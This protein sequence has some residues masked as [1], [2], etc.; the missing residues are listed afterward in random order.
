MAVSLAPN[1][2]IPC[3]YTEALNA[4]AAEVALNLEWGNFSQSGPSHDPTF[5]IKVNAGNDI[6]AE[7][8]GK[9]K[10]EAKNSAAKILLEILKQKY[11]IDS[12]A[13]DNV[14]RTPSPASTINYISMLN[15]YSQRMRTPIQVS[16]RQLATGMDHKPK[17]GC[18]YSV[19]GKKYPE[20]FGKNKNEAKREAARQMYEEIYEI[21]SPQSPPQNL[22]KALPDLT[23][24]QELQHAPEGAAN[25]VSEPATSSTDHE[26]QVDGNEESA[27]TMSKEQKSTENTDRFTTVS[28]DENKSQGMTSSSQNCI[29]EL[30]QYC[31]KLKYSYD[32][33]EVGKSG[34]SH[35]LVLTCKVVVNGCDYPEASGKSKQEAKQKA[36]KLALEALEKQEMS[37]STNVYSTSGQYTSINSSTSS[38]LNASEYLFSTPK[39]KG[40]G[41]RSIAANFSSSM[42]DPSTSQA[43][44]EDS[45]VEFEG[46]QDRL[47]QEFS[48]IQYGLG[49]G[50]F[51][52]VFKAKKKMD[53]RYYAV[54]SIILKDDGKEKREVEL[55][56]RMS[57]ENIVRYYHSWIEHSSKM[58]KN[59]LYIQMELCEEH[60]LQDWLET[61]ANS[62][63]E[64]EPVSISI[65]TQLVAGVKYIHDQKMIHRD[66]KPANI[67]L[68]EGNK[69][70]IGD[71]GLAAIMNEKNAHT[72]DVGTRKYVSPEQQIISSYTNK[73]DIFPL[74]LIYFELFW[75][76]CGTGHEKNAKWQKIRSGDFPSPFP[77]NFE[78]Q[79]KV[80]K[81][82]LTNSPELRPTADD[83][84]Q[85][86]NR[87]LQ[88]ES[89]TI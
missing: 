51:G 54:K 66:L 79:T 69:V 47:H 33:I 58:K 17:F 62:N 70:K 65:F 43:D 27:A 45:W 61:F 71:F 14:S 22:V 56:A 78:F 7:G 87:G 29:G 8:Q 73:T 67:F 16:C 74:G 84:K 31:Q 15:E 55:L 26:K 1:S 46:P 3:K 11:P 80:I 39:S 36:A 59:T 38:N 83:V 32:I 2:D 48:D 57:H 23:R 44:S 75:I 25:L 41:R 30:N 89:K 19:N 4:Y 53:N 10:K 42:N 88:E 35:N 64:K 12:Y 86:L 34:P 49:S 50:A 77:E 20:C 82:M 40:K 52:N 37:V 21:H 72:V 68:S 28:C 13:R 5:F 85:I 9:N 76:F 81:M 18:T 63:R 24:K 60:T 6:S